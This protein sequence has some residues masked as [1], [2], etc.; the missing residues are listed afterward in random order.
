[1][2]GCA[3]PVVTSGKGADQDMILQAL[4]TLADNSDACTTLITSL[5]Q[6]Q[7]PGSA[8]IVI[9]R[10]SASKAHLLLR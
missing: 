1:M 7:A 6:Q 5:Q 9:A 2:I 8:A 3:C 10:W 4:L